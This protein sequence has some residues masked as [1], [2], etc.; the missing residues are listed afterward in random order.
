[1]VLPCDLGPQCY[2]ASHTW[3]ESATAIPAGMAAPRRPTPARCPRPHAAAASAW[4][5][6]R[7]RTSPANRRRRSGGEGQDEVD[8]IRAVGVADGARHCK[9]RGQRRS[10][11]WSLPKQVASRG[12]YSSWPVWDQPNRGVRELS[13]SL[14]RRR[15]NL[16]GKPEDRD[17][18]VQATL[19][20]GPLPARRLPACHHRSRKAG[21]CG[22]DLRRLASGPMSSE[23]TIKCRRAFGISI[24]RFAIGDRRVTGLTTATRCLR[25]ARR[26]V[27][28]LA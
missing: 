9:L 1:M 15:D 10:S 14:R 11:A 24:P 2:R 19:A 7:R 21:S 4:A 26:P 23:Q 6:A 16:S 25:S 27:E 8:R 20:M 17:R 18:T 3:P 13:G 12:R 28:G 22:R 5:A